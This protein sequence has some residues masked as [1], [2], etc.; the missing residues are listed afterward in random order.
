MRAKPFILATMAYLLLVFPLAAVWHMVAFKHIYDELG[1]FDREEPI[2]ALGFLVI[3]IQGLILSLAYPY[4]YR[5]GKPAK[6]GL[7][8]GLL[9][10]LFLWSSQVIAAAAKHQVASLGTWFAIETTYFGIQFALVGLAMGMTYG[11]CTMPAVDS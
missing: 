1:I 8:F 2:V 11:R 10:G 4:F 3:L 5:E 7:K 9:A 6:E